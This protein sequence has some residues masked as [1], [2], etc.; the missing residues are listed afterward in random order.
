MFQM[1]A[2]GSWIGRFGLIVLPY[3]VVPS[4]HAPFSAKRR[5][6]AAPIP[7]AAPVTVLV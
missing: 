6:V 2:A 3:E 5:A 7:E 4:A 1:A